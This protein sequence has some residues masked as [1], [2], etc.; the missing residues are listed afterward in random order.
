MPPTLSTWNVILET[1][2]QDILYAL[3]TM[4]ANP[5]FTLTAVLTLTLGIG[6]NTA[7]FTVIRG[8]LLTPL[9]FH[10]P[11]QLIYFA[12]ENPKRNVREGSFA[13]AE[14]EE[15]RAAAAATTADSSFTSL[16]AFGRPEN[17]ALTGNGS[18][19]EA[20]KGARVSANFLDILGIHPLLG[21]S[22]LQEEDKRGGP[23]VAMISSAL[24]KR[25]FAADPLVAGKAATIDAVPHTI[26]GVLPDGFEFPFAGVD[27]WVT[28]PSEWSL[29][30]PRY[31]GVA[32]L[33]GFGRMKPGA[34]LDQAQAEM[35]VRHEQ[36]RK[37][38]PSPSAAD[39]GATMKVVRLADRLVAGVRPML[40]TLLGAVGF[41]LLIAGANVA[42]LLLA[43]A[44]ARTRE[45]A[46]RAALGAARGRLIRQLVAESL[47]LALAG[48]LAGTLLARWGLTALAYLA[49]RMAPAGVSALY[50]PGV[51]DIRLD[52]SVLAFTLA[53]T[54]V[55]GIL[56]GLFPSLQVSRPDLAAVLR[57]TTAARAASAGNNRSR[58]R[59]GTSPR[60]LLVIGQVAFSMILL[61][62]A[63]LLMQ[64]FVRL[65]SADPGFETENLLTARIALPLA[66][67]DTDQKKA[68]FSREL[69][70]RV[71]SLPGVRAAATA[72]S[73]PTTAWIRTNI[74]E[75]EGAPPWEPEDPAS[76]A[77]VQSVSPD[78]F[79]TL[80]IPLKRGREFTARDNATGAPP[81]MIVNETLARRLWPDYPKNGAN[82]VGLHVK[83]A[84][85]KAVGAMEVV[86]V[87]ADIRE[88]G[89][90]S[91]AVPEFYLPSV[92]HPPQTLY[93]A[94]RI[95]TTEA[96]IANAIRTQVA[97]VDPD[98]AISEIRTMQ[99][100]LDG[101][102]GQ[103]RLTML[104]LGTFAGVALLLALV[105]IYGVIAYSV[106]Q[107]THELGI[108]RAL[109]A[110]Q[111]DLL[112]LVLQQGLTLTLI[113]GALGIGGA[114]G[115][116]R[117]IENMLF[118]VTPTDPLTFA[119]VALLFL[120][121][122]LAATFIPARRA[123]RIDPMAAL[124]M[125]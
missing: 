33:T 58:G 32:T 51:H 95:T 81:L 24:W 29:L 60:G 89:L 122:S 82:P 114:Y 107:R 26:I 124:R 66:R 113:G 48:G 104:L 17:I 44:T 86:G 53:I 12:V 11:Q 43:R 35:T 123:A 39:S 73:L 55:T 88:G 83:E 28:R 1:F 79:R 85:D 49:A 102:L 61:I 77:V 105:G 125:G 119:G 67:Y 40:W 74:T 76:Y 36:Y 78:Y 47:V 65:R 117:I 110:Q 56:F 108:R 21:R 30:P 98:Q 54:V 59:L 63:A 72:M 31:W 6:G 71:E 111:S 14:F 42:S 97:A 84:Y 5:L 93:L 109:G 20:L 3:R 115:L 118:E 121:V 99:G 103:R 116:T 13:P 52:G 70:R 64:S 2:W 90:A 18:G 112:R 96:A 80:G 50:L 15:I 7:I 19:P 34:T 91:R 16:G 62:G 22:F 9:H 10:E 92:V 46:V 27:V 41:V 4:R 37:A 120:L 101:T 23:P 75:V 94:V 106:A 8:V 87:V 100:I 57:E 25:R 68:D 38:H 69:L 45:F